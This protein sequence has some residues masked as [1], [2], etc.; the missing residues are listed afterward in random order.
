MALPREAAS[1]LVRVA[2]LDEL[3]EKGRHLFKAGGKQVAVFAGTGGVFACNNRCPHE[4]YPLME[5]SLAQGGRGDCI[6]TCNWHNWKFDL[7]S[8][9]TLVGGD[10]LR[11]YPVEV[12]DGEVWVDIADPPADEVAAAALDALRDCFRRHDY[13]RMAREISRLQKAGADPLE[14]LRCAFDWT[15]DRFEFGATHAQ[16]G[17]ADWLAIRDDYAASEAERLVPLV[18]VVGHLAWD[19]LREPAF[20]FAEGLLPY[21]AA[22]LV[23]AIEAEDEARAL[24]LAR[25]ALFE[26]RAFREIEEPLAEAALAH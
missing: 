9:E 6:L 1:T 24:R 10:R 12:V 5:G 11:R 19:S 16:A 3:M 22:A 23:A 20:P 8:G 15:A 17:A 25:G 13:G 4:G 7:A 26:G 21:D 14:A 2:P 18:E